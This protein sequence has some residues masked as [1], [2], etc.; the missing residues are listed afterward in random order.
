MEHETENRNEEMEQATGGWGLDQEELEELP[1]IDHELP[2]ETPN[3]QLRP[4]PKGME[5]TQPIKN[6]ELKVRNA[7]EKKMVW[8]QEEDKWMMELRGEERHVWKT[9]YSNAVE[10]L[11][12]EREDRRA[13][14]RSC[15]EARAALADAEVTISGLKE[16][17]KTLKSE[18]AVA[19]SKS[20][21]PKLLRFMKAMEMCST[22]MEG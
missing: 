16:E 10:N 11:E 6:L 21:D 17:I 4:W 5:P 12:K 8:Q 2:P 15:F 18:L 14:E 3:F 7:R 19:Q 9:R 1:A 13:W 20:Q 22:L